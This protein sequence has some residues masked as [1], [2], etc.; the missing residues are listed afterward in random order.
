MSFLTYLQIFKKEY[1]WSKNCSL[2]HTVMQFKTIRIIHELSVS[3][4]LSAK[5]HQVRSIN[6]LTLKYGFLVLAKSLLRIVLAQ[7][8]FSCRSFAFYQREYSC[9]LNYLHAASMTSKFTISRRPFRI[10]S[11]ASSASFQNFAF[12]S[13]E[14]AWNCVL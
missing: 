1:K 12:V 7:N 10:F 3:R 4:C 9:Y 13:S 6:N 2:R 14:R 5:P 11:V 8:R